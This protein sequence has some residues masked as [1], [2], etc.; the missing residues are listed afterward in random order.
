MARVQ[1]ATAAVK[2][3][4]E[5]AYESPRALVRQLGLRWAG[6][7]DFDL[8]AA[9][10]VDG[11]NAV[12]PRWLSTAQDALHPNR[13]WEGRAVWCNPPYARIQ[14]WVQKAEAEVVRG[15]CD[16]VVMLLPVRAASAWWH[17]IC[18]GGL[19]RLDPIK[20]RVAFIDPK[21]GKPRSGN[22]EASVGAVC[23]LPY[24]Q[25]ADHR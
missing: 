4:K 25:A 20:G 5:Q 7:P 22:F 10:A 23:R 15:S 1:H 13:R 8:D 17:M 11:S 6:G 16:V 2:G 3:E 21:T 9:A 12:A 19:W 24:I 18:H 14:D